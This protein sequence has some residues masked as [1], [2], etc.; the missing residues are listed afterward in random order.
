MVIGAGIAGLVTARVMSEHVDRVTVLERDR[1]PQDAVTRKS[2]P[3]GRHAH[4]LLATGQQLLA[5]W[6]PGLVDELVRAGAVPLDAKDLVWHQAGAHRVRSDLGFLT[7]S[8]SRPLLGARC[9]S[10]SCGN[11]PTCPSPT[12]RPWTAWSWK[13]A[14]WPVSGP[15]EPSTGPTSWST[16]PA[17][18]PVSSTSWPQRDSRHRG[19]RHPYRHG[20]RNPDRAAAAGRSRRR[21]RPC[22]RQP[23]PRSPHG[24][25]GAGGGRPVDRHRGFAPR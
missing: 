7:M 3:Q 8:M 5:G 10:G 17:A 6:F 4:V 1:L 18:T 25:D 14:G 12:R 22:G 11:G 9:A 2:V 15:T 24:H 23:G 16:A 20:L 13:A 21:S 19:L